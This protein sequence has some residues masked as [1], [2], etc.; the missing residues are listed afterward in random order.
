MTE[1]A[2]RGGLYFLGGV[3]CT[4]AFLMIL[5]IGFRES[6]PSY[7][8]GFDDGLLRAHRDSIE[9]VVWTHGDKVELLIQRRKQ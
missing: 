6:L 7:K 4:L 8:Q 1:N 2:F 9:Y 3:V 5:Q